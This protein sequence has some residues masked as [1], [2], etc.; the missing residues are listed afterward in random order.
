MTTSARPRHGRRWNGRWPGSSC[1]APATP[2]R[3]R[4]IGAL[5]SRCQGRRR[6]ELA[7]RSVPASGGEA[8]L[9]A[10]QPDRLAE[11]LLGPV[12]DRPARPAR[13]RSAPWPRRTMTATQVLFTLDA[14]RRPPRTS[15]D[16]RAGRRSDRHPARPVRVGRARPCGD[17]SAARP[18]AR[19]TLRLGQ[20]DPQVFSGI[21]STSCSISCRDLRQRR[22]F[23]AALTMRITELLRTLAEANPDAYL[24]DLASSLNNLGVRLADVGQRQA[25]LAPAQEAVAIRRQLAEADPDAYL[26]DLAMSLNN[27]GN[28]LAEAGQRQ[29]ALAPAREAAPAVPPAGRGQPRRLPARPGQRAEQPGHPAGRGRAAAGRPGRRPRKPPQS[30]ASWP[31]PT[32][33]PTS[34]TSPGAEQPGRSSWPRPGSGRPLWPRPGK[35]PRSTASWPQPTPTPTS[36][37]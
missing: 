19:R 32:P 36:P 37:T 33:T 7:G 34:P 8:G 11:L 18:A 1:S 23:S 21:R 26:P 10:V 22:T 25:A 14:H 2:D 24:P 5:A 4:A 9:G 3:A 17:P 35:P 31:R 12:L 28:Q 27:L 30:T 13:P 6:G 20:Q 16:R 15:P 29:A